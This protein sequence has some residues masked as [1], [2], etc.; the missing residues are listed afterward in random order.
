MRRQIAI[1]TPSATV[2]KANFQRDGESAKFFSHFVGG[3]I[4][5]SHGFL[6]HLSIF[7]L[8]GSRKVVTSINILLLAG[9][10]FTSSIETSKCCVFNGVKTKKNYIFL[11]RFNSRGK[12]FFRGLNISFYTLVHDWADNF[13]VLH[14]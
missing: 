3:F 10:K 13:Q 2:A 8:I 14:P 7:F 11:I 9:I 1:K 12:E 6:K 5:N 4:R